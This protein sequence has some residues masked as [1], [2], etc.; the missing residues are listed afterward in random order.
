MAQ[1]VITGTGFTAIRVG[2]PIP[3]NASSPTQQGTALTYIEKGTVAVDPAS[4]AT[5]A[6]G[7]VSISIA[8]AKPGDTV[9]MTPPTAG[10][11]AGLLVCD[12]R[13]S[14]AGTVKVRIH[15]TTGGSVDEP[16][17]TWFY[18]LVRA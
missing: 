9:L 12:A 5:G 11:T 4:I 8:N 16:S 6:V 10:L 18:M 3:G 15:N 2:A 7:E 13:C 1:P 17:A 14:A